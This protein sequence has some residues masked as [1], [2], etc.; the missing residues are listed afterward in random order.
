MKTC[1]KCNRTLP[2][3]HYWKDQTKP[4]GRS[5]T[6]RDCAQARAR[7]RYALNPKPSVAQSRTSRPCRH[8][9]R[10][11][12]HSHYKLPNSWYCR[13]CVSVRKE[14]RRLSQPPAHCDTCGVLTE[15]ANLLKTVDRCTNCETQL[16]AQR[17][18]AYYANH[19]YSTNLQAR[20]K[21]RYR[22][23]PVYRLKDN[24][25]T[26][27]ANAFANRGYSKH[28]R[29]EHILDCDYSD[30]CAWIESQFADGMNWHNRHLWH[31]DH[32]VPVSLAENAE[33]L[34]LL[35]RWDN[36]QPLWAGE[37][38]SKSATVDRSDPVYLELLE[39]RMGKR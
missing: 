7:K 35:N 11:L 8:C 37:N 16:R 13:E 34:L 38:Q 28:S 18:T 25:V 20:R 29:T 4:Q 12:D 10:T 2:L 3:D 23:D 39:M 22:R 17:K 31:L 1:N 24:I 9:Q 32:R 30:F 21:R 14:Q 33:E 26:L 5:R 36:F 6:C 27:I 15:P 19:N